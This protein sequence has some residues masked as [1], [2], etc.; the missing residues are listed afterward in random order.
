MMRYLATKGTQYE[1]AHAKPATVI[2]ST[3]RYNE[4]CG[5]AGPS[6]TTSPQEREKNRRPRRNV[7]VHPLQN[8]MVI[9]RLA[10][11]GNRGEAPS[12]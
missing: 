5:G 12:E 7:H 1:Y 2:A 10:G 6:V 8:T 9:T 11:R 3:A 4:I